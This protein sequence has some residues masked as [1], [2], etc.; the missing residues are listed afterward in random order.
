MMKS[1]NNIFKNNKDLLDIPEVNELVEYTREIEGELINNKFD[2]NYNKEDI[3]LMMIGDI[4]NGILQTLK[5]DE[6]SIRFNEIPRVDFKESIINLRSYIDKMC[7]E[8]NIRL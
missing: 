3:L 7:E 1:I 8:Y 4:K 6:E 2:N 5:D